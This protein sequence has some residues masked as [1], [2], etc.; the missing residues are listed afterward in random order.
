MSVYRNQ[1]AAALAAVTVLGPTRYAWLGRRSRPLP[2]TFDAALDDADRRRYLVACLAEELYH[3]FYCYGGPVPARWGESQPR[4]AEPQLLEAL[5]RANSGRGSWE[6]GWTVERVD[7]EEVVATGRRLRVRAVVADC[8]PSA[9]AP[10]ATVRLRLPPE[11]RRL[12]PGFWLAVSD[13]PCDR[14]DVRVYWNVTHAGAPALVEALTTPLNTAGVP[15][16]LKVADH[17]FRFDRRDAAVLYLAADAFRAARTTIA[18]AAAGLTGHLRP[19][20][21]AF[22]L[23]LAPGVGAAEDI[24]GESFGVR[25]CG[26]LADAVVAAHERSAGVGAIAT[27]FA[28]L[29]VDVDAPYRAGRDVL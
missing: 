18:R 27:H 19:G 15:F 21:P 5:S 8:R 14:F 10:E 26:Q 28:E 20:T 23:D 24:D 1:V 3:S 13:A 4:W 17:P 2:V 6:N 12:S 29:G 25:R 7:G 16:R 9:V 22:T 11:L